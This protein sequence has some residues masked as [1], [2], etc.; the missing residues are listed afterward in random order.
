MKNKRK[1]YSPPLS[2]RSFIHPWNEMEYL[3]FKAG[4][5]LFEGRNRHN[6]DPF[7]RRLKIL[8]TKH[9]PR[10]ITILGLEGRILIADFEDKM[11]K[12]IEFTEKLASRIIKL[13]KIW[14]RCPD[15]DWTSVRSLYITLAMLY[16]ENQQRVR[17]QKAVTRCA[18]FCRK[19]RLAL[20]KKQLERGRVARWPG[21]R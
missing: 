6:A 4:F 17:A 9:D 20:N 7:I 8:V 21:T 15:Y 19:H 12:E 3:Y 13:I 18:K 5:W 2:K 10:G 16:A 1:L 11:E 14:P